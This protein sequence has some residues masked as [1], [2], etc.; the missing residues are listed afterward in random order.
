MV[1]PTEP[2]KPDAPSI[3]KTINVW[4]TAGEIGI[5]IALPLVVLLLLGIK[6]DKKLGT[7]PLF[8][9][10]ALIGSMVLSTIAIARKIKK[11]T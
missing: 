8:I 3:V 5:L 1:S 6:L 9:I 4:G 7:T 10:V 11:I 2:K